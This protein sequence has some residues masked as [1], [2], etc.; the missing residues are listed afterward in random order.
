MDW[1]GCGIEKSWTQL[2]DLLSRS[3]L[4]SNQDPRF[5]LLI[6]TLK[7]FLCGSAVKNLPERQEI[8]VQSPGGGSSPGEGNGNPLQYSCLEHTMDRGTWWVHGTARVEYNLATKPNTLK[9]LLHNCTQSTNVFIAT[10]KSKILESHLSCVSRKETEKQIRHVQPMDC[11]YMTIY[12]IYI[13]VWINFMCI[14]RFQKQYLV[15]N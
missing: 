8:Q 1:I 3:H 11:Y 12:I 2:S 4:G 9:K 10:G 13:N 5:Y 6:Y 15:K 14:K 7:G